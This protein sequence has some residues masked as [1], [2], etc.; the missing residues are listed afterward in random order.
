KQY[1]AMRAVGMNGR[2]LKRMI[3][4]EA[5]PYAFFGC[6]FGCFL[7]LPLSKMMHDFL[8]TSHFGESFAWTFPVWEI[9]IIF[10]LVFLSVIAAVYLPSK[11][12]CE[13]EVTETINEL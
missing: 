3:A 9:L 8:I 7:G 2:Q 5:Y 4:A 11:R 1:G 6:S 13:M 10:L 12:I